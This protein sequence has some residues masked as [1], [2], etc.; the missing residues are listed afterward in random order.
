MKYIYMTG[1]LIWKNKNTF[2][3]LFLQLLLSMVILLSLVGR[4]QNIV[5]TK[6]MVDVFSDDN[7]Y[8]FS[9]YSYFTPEEGVEELV[10]EQID[11]PCQICSITEQQV[12]KKNGATVEIYGYNDTLIDH[13]R[14]ELQ[15]GNWFSKEKKKDRKI[16]RAHV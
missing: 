2:L 9:L 3:L 8:Y 1:N 6:K 16:G 15:S 14:L 7:A 5:S 4:V 13:S 10:K 12:Q 11:E